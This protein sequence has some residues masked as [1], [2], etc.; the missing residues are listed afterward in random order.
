MAG[1]EVDGLIYVIG[2]SNATT[3][4]NTVE[5]YDPVANG[6]STRTNIP[7][8]RRNMTADVI[9]GKIYIIGGEGSAGTLDIVEIYDPATDTWITGEPML[10]AR[11]EISSAVIGGSIYVIGGINGSVSAVN[12]EYNPKPWQPQN[13]SASIQAT[14]ITLQWNANKDPDIAHY[15]VYR[16]LINGFTP[17]VNTIIGIADNPDTTF[18]DRNI[19]P[20]T[21]YYYRITA[22][23]EVGQ[24]S[25]QYSTQISATTQNYTLALGIE[26]TLLT[27]SDTLTVPLSF[28]G[29]FDIVNVTSFQFAATYDS[30]ILTALT[31]DTIG[32]GHLITLL[33]NIIPGK[34]SVAGYSTE[35]LRGALKT[36]HL[37]FIVNMNA[38]RDTTTIQLQDVLFN[39]G[40]PAVNITSTQVR[41]SPRYGDVS[42]NKIITSYDAAL[43]LQNVVG[44][45]QFSQSLE[46]KADVTYNGSVTALDAYY[47]LLRATNVIPRFPVE[48]SLGLKIAAPPQLNFPVTVN[49]SITS[50]H[51]SI[52]LHIGG[53]GEIR[54]ESMYLEI[55]FNNT[56][57]SFNSVQFNDLFGNYIHG[58]HAENG[59]V[60]VA[61]AGTPS[62][63]LDKD[64][65]TVTFTPNVVVN[66]GD[67]SRFVKIR[68]IEIND[69]AV[70]ISSVEEIT[71][72]VPRIFNLKQNY[73]NPFN[74]ETMIQYELPKPSRVVL[75]I[76]NILGQEVKTLINTEQPAGSYSVKWNGR[77]ESGYSVAPGIYFY[78]LKAGEFEK[79]LKMMLIK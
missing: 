55:E 22:V 39:E 7:T 51:N 28:L 1:A 25:R 71:D 31:V 23:D 15:I 59:V 14:K 3:Y 43:V 72:G 52:A 70:S 56:L 48:D 73:P 57:C 27:N 53:T 17:S 16:S 6:W 2:G 75:K 44:I 21:T 18:I 76:Y 45:I 9:G 30:T 24:E 69:R 67:I 79:T 68:R 10:A 61:L 5:V 37:K 34:V 64:I 50:E 19:Q 47:I 54:I 29:N 62:A 36:M 60:R 13:L 32:F 78:H 33:T 11:T 40:N 38:G 49:N 77:N 12:E 65:V 42:G 41:I 26:D 74:P 4:L 35:P 58:E 63:K 46:E 20:G 66:A 8:A